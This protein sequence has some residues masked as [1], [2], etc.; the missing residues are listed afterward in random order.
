[1]LEEFVLGRKLSIYCNT[2]VWAGR[3][4]HVK[5]MNFLIKSIQTRNYQVKRNLF[6]KKV[7]YKCLLAR[8]SIGESRTWVDNTKT[9]YYENNQLS[10]RK[11]QVHSIMIIACTLDFT[12]DGASPSRILTELTEVRWCDSKEFTS[13]ALLAWY[14]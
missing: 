14:V 6:S 8:A 9:K 2:W 4:P 3:R 12:Q 1:M 5:S 7:L 13:V 10:G 11:F